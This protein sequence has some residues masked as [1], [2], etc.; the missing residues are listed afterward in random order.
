MYQKEILVRR[1]WNEFLLLSGW[2]QLWR[3]DEELE[4]KPLLLHIQRCQS[5]LGIWSGCPWSSSLWRISKHI[6]L[7]GCTGEEPELAGG[8]IYPVWTGNALGAPRMSQGE[9]PGSGLSG[10]PPGLIENR[11]LIKEHN[12]DHC[13]VW[14]DGVLWWYNYFICI[15]I[16]IYSAPLYRMLGKSLL[17]H[18]L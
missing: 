13:V 16:Y 7:G 4:I 17:I 14:M 18:Y 9:S 10:F 15:H 3:S 5:Y 11:S 12:V 1:G 8:S 2:T 6:P